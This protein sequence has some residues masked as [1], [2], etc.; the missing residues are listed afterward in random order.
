[1]SQH[2]PGPYGEPR[3]PGPV[4]GPHGQPQQGQP[5]YGYPQQPPAGPAPQPGYGYPQP[6]PN[7]YAQPQQPGQ[8]TQQPPYGQQLPYGQQPPYGRMPPPPP[9]GGGSGRGRTVGIV[10][11]AV[12]AVAAVVGGAVLFTGGDGSGGP[13]GKGGPGGGPARGEVAPYTLEMPE[14]L[15]DGEYTKQPTGADPAKDEGLADKAT[16][17]RLGVKNAEQ[18]TGVYGNSQ[19]QSLY[20]IGVHG[21]VDDP[22][23]SVD[24]LFAQIEDQNA[25]AAA[26]TE[27]ETVTPVT[28]YSPGGFDGAVMKCK[29]ETGVQGEG[30]SRIKAEVAYCVWGDTSA[31]GIVQHQL[32]SIAGAEAS[33]QVMT[34]EEL[35][36]ETVAVRDEVRV[37]KK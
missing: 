19:K 20:V 6:G 4:P 36:V 28:E 5:G 8:Y 26:G 1:M 9:T 31:L 3:Q 16:A 22:E 23:K 30:E 37:E 14:K 32:T 21:R 13:D 33:G 25:Q 12:V 17:D 29:A 34:T 15:L 24:A 10:A 18:A 2:Q 35:S 11:G 7:P 27:T